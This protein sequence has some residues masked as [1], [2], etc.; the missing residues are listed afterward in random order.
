MTSRVATPEL[1]VTPILPLAARY[2]SEADRTR[3]LHPD[4]I[5]A[6]KASPLASMAA[7]RNL[8][9]SELSILDA[10]REFEALAPVCGSSVWTLWNNATV[11]HLYG[12]QL[13]AGGRDFL[14]GI[15]AAHETVSFPGG[16]G[17]G[18]RGVPSAEQPGAIVANG[19]ARFA[20]ASRYGEWLSVIVDATAEG[21]ERGAPRDLR[22]ALLR[23]DDPA[24]VITPTWDGAALRASAT[25]DVRIRDAVV[26]AAR[27]VP[28]LLRFAL[29]AP[30]RPVIH[31]R[32]RED[33]VG[34]AAIWLAAMA[35]GIADAALQDA[36]AN[37]RD[38]VAAGGR[39]MADL[40]VVH[41]N[42]GQAWGRVRV[43]RAA[44]QTAA[45]ATDARIGAGGI[46]SEGDYLEQTGVGT[47]A[48]NLCREAMELVLRVL[49]GN[50]L[51]E[52]ASFERRYRDFQALPLH[53]IAHQDRISEQIGREL[54]GLESRSVL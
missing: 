3:S 24:V 30:E 41:A 37:I 13:G 53:I 35:T 46:P 34:L 44:W 15:V 25:D 49:G 18:V 48:L 19:P 31:P 47:Q 28:W 22:F 32:Y 33:W 5:A 10:G 51:R 38:R 36:V 14:A 39:R 45:V 50:G 17:S 11:F 23:V 2:A 27:V 4:V 8:G 54:L 52:S 9:G 26:P 16:A 29:R 1:L 40:P 12:A 20:S 6:L 42:L 7:T 21:S 43:A